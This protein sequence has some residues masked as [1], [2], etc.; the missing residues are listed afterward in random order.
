MRILRVLYNQRAFYA[1]ILD[2][3]HLLCLN[4][5]LGLDEPIPLREVRVL[6]VVLPT[7]IVCVGLNYKSHAEEMGLALPSE[8]LIFLKPPSAV[9]GSG[10]AVVLPEGCGR[11]DH[12]AELGIVIGQTGRHI[13]PEDAARHI[14]GY[15]CANDVTDREIQKRDG[16]YARA[17]GFDTFCPVGPWIETEVAEPRDLA[18]R[19]LV[20]GEVRQDGNTRDMIFGPAELVSFI[21]RV[22][23]LHPGDLILTGT[24]AGI[25]PL[26]PGDTVSVEIEN[27]GLLINPVSAESGGAE[28]IQ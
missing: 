8:P 17:K 7:K 12:E 20:N 4:K 10:D 25:G 5:A 14:F 22:M 24:P 23:T 13:R 19:A 3:D 9:V 18:V 6:P 26:A 11:V 28:Q 15:T 2:R 21:S 1:S 16:L 27:V